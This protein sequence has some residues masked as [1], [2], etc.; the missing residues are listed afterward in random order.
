M[1]WFANSVKVHTEQS[2]YRPLILVKNIVGKMLVQLCL[3]V[4]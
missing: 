3:R 4:A 2:F 1:T